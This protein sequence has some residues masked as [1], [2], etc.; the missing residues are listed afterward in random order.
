[1]AEEWPR[2][3]FL[4][5]ALNCEDLTATD[6]LVAVAYAWSALDRP[7]TWLSTSRA[8]QL[9]SL[10]ATALK[11]ST[12]R[13]RDL[14]WLEVHE[15]GGS[16]RA[17]RY[18]MCVPPSGHEET[19]SRSTGH[20]ETTTSGHEETSSDHL[21]SREDQNSGPEGTRFWSP[22]DHEKRTKNRN[23]SSS[24]G[25]GPHD[26]AP[27]S[28]DHAERVSKL[29]QLHGEWLT[30]EERESLAVRYADKTPNYLGAIPL[31]DLL[32]KVRRKTAA[33]ASPSTPVVLDP[34]THCPSGSPW[35][36]DGT[37]CAD[38]RQHE[39]HNEAEAS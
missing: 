25:A 26:P 10:G 30:Q 34:Q 19:S 13:L 16:H 3:R 5:A 18:A 2:N 15:A 17:T 36:K 32:R 4:D 28:S 8:L 38:P 7:T 33:A 31:E 6:K 20:E 27:L 14:G 24:A 35:G 29:A 21:G 12:K 22:G 11:R 39:A 37:C 9:T 1:M 23:K